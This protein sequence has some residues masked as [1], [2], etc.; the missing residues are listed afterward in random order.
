MLIVVHHRNVEPLDQPLLQ[1]EA[2]R[3]RDVLEVDAAKDRCYPHHRLDDLV[4]V[5]RVQTDRKRV[6]VRELLEER[7]L[8]LH[9]GQCTKWTDVT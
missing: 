2:A 4:N 8:A 1:L 9:H 6:D 7:R 5:F 3:R